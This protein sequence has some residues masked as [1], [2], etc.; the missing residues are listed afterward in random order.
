MVNNQ[1]VFGALLSFEYESIE[2]I[3]KVYNRI[4]V[5]LPNKIIPFASEPSGD[6]LYFD[7]SKSD[8]KPKI[9]L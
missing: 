9:V 3:I 7:Y 1:K 6:Y 4:K 8:T 5:A 2:N